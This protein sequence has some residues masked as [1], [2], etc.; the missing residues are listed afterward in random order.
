MQVYS[1]KEVIIVRKLFLGQ[2]RATN[3]LL[4]KTYHQFYNGFPWCQK[5]VQ[6][7]FSTMNL[8]IKNYDGA[9]PDIDFELA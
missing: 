6:P 1:W 3:W 5:G 9:V 8:G 7:Y 4:F 2:Q